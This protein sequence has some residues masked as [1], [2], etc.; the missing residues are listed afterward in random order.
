VRGHAIHGAVMMLARWTPYLESEMRGLAGVVGPGCVCLDAGAATG[1]YTL[2]LSRLAGPSGQVHAVEP[3][4]LAHALSRRVLRAACGPNVSY[5]AL[6]LGAEAGSGVMSVP[7][8]R[9]GPV[10][11]RSFLAGRFSGLGA[12]AE[13]ARH[14]EVAVEVDTIDALVPRAGITRLD[15]IK[16]DVEGAELQVLQGGEHSIGKFR[17]AMLIEI[18][19]RHTA[20]YQ[21]TAGEVAGWILPR[22]YRMY[23]WQ[24][25]WQ[26]VSEISASQRNYLFRPD[27]A[28]D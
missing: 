28:A 20:R 8:R 13:F 2:A 19:A 11:G 10:T 9:R 21:H 23:A 14:E 7:F 25:S 3:L 5:Y 6:A 22:G 4:S 27:P 16:I 24:H 17:P 26:E 15:F 18:E 12:N 1:L